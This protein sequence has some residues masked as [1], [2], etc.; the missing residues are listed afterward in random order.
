MGPSRDNLSSERLELLLQAG[1]LLGASLD[2]EATLA[3]LAALLVPRLADGY[4]ID[5][6]SERGEIRRI[7]AVDGD[8]AKQGLAER[9]KHLGPLNPRAPQGIQRLLEAGK[10]MVTEQ[11]TDE[12]LR[13]GA[14]DD[15]HL[16]ILRGLQAR[17]ITAVPL[18]ARGRSIGLLWLYYSTTSDRIFRASD[19]PFLDE[20]AARAA[21]AIENARLWRESQS[22]IRARDEFLSMASHE[23]RTP[24]TSIFLRIQGE[25][26]RMK[27]QPDYQAG[28]DEQQALLRAVNQQAVKLE[29]L[30][31][32]M[33]DVSRMTGGGTELDRQ[34][35]DLGQTVRGAVAVL[36]DEAKRAGST[37]SLEAPDGIIGWW[38]PACVR[39]VVMALVSNAIKYGEGKPIA[40]VVTREGKQGRVVV[41]DQGIG[42]TPENLGRIFERFEREVSARNYGGFGLGLWIARQVVEANGGTIH[43]ESTLGQGST[44]RV[45]LPL[46]SI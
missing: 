5:L 46:A 11:V 15:E 23:L 9:L 36:E 30:V 13:A 14:R 1:E 7:A 44:F 43:A 37:L 26:R 35:L 12:G 18:R 42:I 10:T 24:L 8:P 40:V 20:L 21:L 2:Y 19:V 32:A 45:E 29:H 27:R 28:R 4:A 6:V 31:E 38:D 3:N 17:S 16:A 39:Q 22:A 33:L 41:Q 25:L 34:E